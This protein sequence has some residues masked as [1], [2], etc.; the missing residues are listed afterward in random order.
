VCCANSVFHVVK[1]CRQECGRVKREPCC[2]N[3]TASWVATRVL[4]RS[5]AIFIDTASYWRSWTKSSVSLP[6]C[7]DANALEFNIH[8]FDVCLFQTAVTYSSRLRKFFAYCEHVPKVAEYLLDELPSRLK[9][10]GSIQGGGLV[11]TVLFMIFTPHNS[12]LTVCYFCHGVYC[13]SY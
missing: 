5:V 3:L 7:Y 12:A 13:V 11:I 4:L 2:V 1:S 8:I 9:V 10:S 6:R